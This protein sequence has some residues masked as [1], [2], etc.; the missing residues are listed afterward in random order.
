M[1]LYVVAADLSTKKNAL[2]RISESASAVPITTSVSQD[3]TE[4]CLLSD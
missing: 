4:L 3:T 2:V 1:H